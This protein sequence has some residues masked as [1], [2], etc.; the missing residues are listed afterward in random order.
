MR[1]TDLHLVGNRGKLGLGELLFSRED[2]TDGLSS[3]KVSAVKTC[4]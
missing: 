4:K 1:I 2:H 3:A